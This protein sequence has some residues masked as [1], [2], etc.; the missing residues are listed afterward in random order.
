[1][2]AYRFEMAKD[3][4][5]HRRGSALVLNAEHFAYR[6]KRRKTPASWDP[7]TTGATMAIAVKSPE[8]AVQISSTTRS[9]RSA[10]LKNRRFRLW[11]GHIASCQLTL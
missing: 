2:A 1:M 7:A 6:S 9:G 4:A 10:R 3:H 11:M 8:I 5:Q